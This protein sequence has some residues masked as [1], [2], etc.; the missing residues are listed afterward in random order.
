[1]EN[2]AEQLR[3]SCCGQRLFD[4][5]K[6]KQHKGAQ[7][8]KK[9]YFAGA[10]CF[11]QKCIKNPDLP[12]AQGQVVAIHSQL[13]FLL[14]MLLQPY[15]MLNSLSALLNF[16]HFLCSLSLSRPTPLGYSQM[17]GSHMAVLVEAFTLPLVQGLKRVKVRT[18]SCKFS[19]LPQASS[20]ES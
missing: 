8:E 19:S 1:M 16:T 15:L 13:F 10:Y 6:M 11:I 20:P 14:V 4:F 9:K 12:R 17:N 5:K 18:M 3:V 7:T 2:H